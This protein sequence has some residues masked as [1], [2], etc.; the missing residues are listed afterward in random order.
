MILKCYGGT[1]GQR[2]PGSILLFVF[3]IDPTDIPGTGYS[4]SAHPPRNKQYK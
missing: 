2:C 1:N 4:R 3:I